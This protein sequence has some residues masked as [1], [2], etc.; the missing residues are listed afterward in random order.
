MQA[1]GR[2]YSAAELLDD[3]EAGARFHDGTFL[4]L[5]LGPR[6]YH[7]V[8][9]PT[10]GLIRCARHVPGSLLPVNA[11]A[12]AAIPDLFARNER[13]I[14]YVDG[15]LGRLA[16]VAV[17]AF[18]VGRISASFDPLWGG[19]PGAPEW[20]TNYPRSVSSQRRYRPPVRVRR[21]DELMIFHLG[22]TVVLLFE[23]GAAQ[24]APDLEAGSDIRLGR[25]IARPV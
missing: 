16:M 3:G 22:S 10:G 11:G 8:H 23:P 24:L 5:Y 6:H 2:W 4:T 19:A 9:A 7:R 21:G 20:R 18:N 1:K 15:P 25:M 12:V 17:G 14:V 13:L